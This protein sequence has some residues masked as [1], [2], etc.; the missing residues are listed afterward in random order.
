MNIHVKKGPGE[1]AKLSQGLGRGPTTTLNSRTRDRFGLDRILRFGIIRLYTS[2]MY[3][4][5]II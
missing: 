3:T 1:G 4:G 5:L 2:K